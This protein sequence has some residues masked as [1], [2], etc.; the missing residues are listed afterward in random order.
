MV[1][2]LATGIARSAGQSLSD[3]IDDPSDCTTGKATDGLLPGVIDIISVEIRKQNDDLIATVEFRGDPSFGDTVSGGILV[4]DPAGFNPH[5]ESD[6]H[7]D[8]AGNVMFSYVGDALS[9]AIAKSVVDSSG[10]WVADTT[11]GFSTIRAGNIVTVRIPGDELGPESLWMAY[12]SSRLFEIQARCDIAGGDKNGLPV[13][14]VPALVATEDRFEAAGNVRISVPEADGLLANDIDATSIVDVDAVSDHGGDVAVDPSGAFTFDPSPG[15]SGT[16]S[17]SYTATDG[18][19]GVSTADVTIEI[20]P[21]LWFVDA[22]ATAEPSSG[23]W[24]APFPDL[25]SLGHAEGPKPSDAILIFGNA[26]YPS[27]LVLDSAQVVIGQGVDMDAVL[28]ANGYQI[29]PYSEMLADLPAVTEAPVLVSDSLHAIRLGKDNRIFGLTIGDTPAGAGIF[30][31]SIGTL[32]VSDVKVTGRGAILDVGAGLIDAALDSA[33]SDSAVTDAILL[34]STGGN[35]TVF[36]PV[37]LKSPGRDG[38]RIT[39]GSTDV[40]IPKLIVIDADSGAAVKIAGSPGGRR[41]FDRVEVVSTAGRGFEVDEGGELFVGSGS[42]RTGGSAF[43]LASTALRVFLDSLRSSGMHGM[44]FLSVSGMLVIGGSAR[45]D[46]SLSSAIDMEASAL[47]MKFSEL[48]V[49]QANSSFGLRV[50]DSPGS[51]FDAERVNIENLGGGAVMMQGLDSVIVDSGVIVARGGPSIDLRGIVADIHIDS[52]AADSADSGIVL[53]QVGGSLDVHNEGSERSG[54]LSR[55]SG[56]AL[57]AGNVAELA[58]DNLDLSEVAGDAVHIENFGKVLL[59]GLDIQDVDSTAVRASAGGT[60]QV[61]ENAISHVRNGIMSFE[62]STLTLSGNRI[63]DTDSTAVIVSNA[64]ASTVAAKRLTSGAGDVQARIVDNEVVTGASRAIHAEAL[65]DGSLTLELTGN[66]ATASA[67]D[68]VLAAPDTAELML[69]GF[70]GGDAD[71]VTAY[72]RRLNLGSPRILVMGRVDP[73]PGGQAD[74]A[75][76]DKSVSN[77]EPLPER[78]IE[79]RIRVTNRGPSP[80]LSVV[81]MDSLPDGLAYVPAT[82]TLNG[83]LQTDEADEDAADFAV[84]KPRTVTVELGNLS[85]ADTAV[86]TFGARPTQSFA[87]T[88]VT[89]RAQVVAASPDSTTSDNQA[90]V[91][92]GI[93]LNTASEAEDVPA[94]FALRQN[95]PNPFNPSTTIEFDVPR[96]TFVRITIL[97]VL[98][99]IVQELAAREFNPGR[100]EVR[101]N[102]GEGLGATSGLYFYRLEAGS[103]TSTRPMILLK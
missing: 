67:Y 10:A 71:A 26:T 17:F 47:R 73:G 4:L 98:G 78:L 59:R 82:M 21:A 45:I 39:G 69:G 24:S 88:S 84:T 95:Y 81:V 101:W 70:A 42:V 31:D 72:V 18:K 27:N 34:R 102:A 30:G 50:S 57:D 8:H 75:L 7:F 63:E 5:V 16:D 15:F 55:I 32:V 89:N 41:T 33:A 83:V 38:L 14:A 87:G 22:G 91:S 56:R 74:L 51:T 85:V 12:A 2:L 6:W 9:T 1:I 20:G 68:Y 29:P 37:T 48:V 53:R 62:V 43:D 23:R 80:A 97:N 58:F 13:L 11:S 76:L 93:K 79:Y 100:Y 49:K 64:S 25:E 99:Q 46:S 60:L 77:P 103:F 40:D 28:R 96:R 65:L 19:G 86:V 36:S 90:D 52:L 54:K 35:L 92:I 44:R 66:A 61:E 94:S 3:P